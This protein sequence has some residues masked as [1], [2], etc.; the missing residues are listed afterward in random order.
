MTQYGLLV[1]SEPSRL[2]FC[3][4]A[5][6]LLVESEHLGLVQNPLMSLPSLKG[7][8][9]QS[10]PIFDHL[11]VREAAMTH[12]TNRQR[13]RADKPHAAMATKP[14]RT[15]LA[16]ADA[17]NTTLA[18]AAGITN[19]AQFREVNRCTVAPCAVS[20]RLSLGQPNIASAVIG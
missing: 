18:H 13:T 6:A 20:G 10:H 19:A 1:R 11:A 8:P 2:S 17:V 15:H 5:Q 4:Q 14:A 9:I 3:G 12:R 16:M 7:V